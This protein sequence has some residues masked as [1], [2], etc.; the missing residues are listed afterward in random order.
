MGAGYTGLAA[1]RRLAMS[2][3]SVLVLE[4]DRVGAGASSR[5]GGQVLT[6]LK[7]DPAALVA[8]HGESKARGLFEIGTRAIADLEATIRDEAIACDYERVGHIQA[9]AKPSHFEAFR[10]EQALLARV[11]GH[12]VEIVPPA[13]QRTELGSA[14]YHG[15]LIDEGSRAINPAR[16]VAG[17][18]A[19]ARRRGACV[20]TGRAVTGVRRADGGWRVSIPSGEVAAGDVLVATN[21]YTG[22]ATP[23][24][25]RRL[26]PIGSYV[27]VTEAI[28]ADEAAALLP[29]RRVVFDTKHFLF[30]F[31]LT[32]DNRLLFGGRAEFSAPSTA[33]TLRAATVLHAGLTRVFPALAGKAIDY[34]WSGRVAFT[35]DQMPRAGKLDGMYFAAG[36]CGHG[37][38]MATHLGDVIARRMA[39]ESIAHP[40]MDDR[41]PAIPLYSGTPWFLPLAGAYYKVMDWLP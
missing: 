17:L 34:V 20:I 12:R 27:I 19:A 16:Y 32:P 8:A 25:R 37:I 38:A 26:I 11:F 21:G 35:R 13:D 39:G 14:A 22:P 10:E 5:S 3:A 6:G 40:M 2:G 18:A 24:L 23:A 9:A 36:Y 30:Y 1:A 31:R 15:L 33:A 4:R 41:M 7:V 29:K 28:A